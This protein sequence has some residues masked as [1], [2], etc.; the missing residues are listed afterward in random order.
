MSDRRKDFVLN[1]LPVITLLSI[2]LPDKERENQNAEAL[3][4]NAFLTL[5]NSPDHE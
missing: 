1:L 2:C 3:A 5:Y 4:A